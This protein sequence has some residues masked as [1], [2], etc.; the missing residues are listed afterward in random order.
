MQENEPTID[1]FGGREECTVA[2]AAP[3]PTRDAVYYQP[4]GTFPLL[5]AVKEPP[6]MLAIFCLI[7]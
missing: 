3:Q 5:H 6:T 1:R 2:P 7:S 4:I